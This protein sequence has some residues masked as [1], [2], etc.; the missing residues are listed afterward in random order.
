[1]T[2]AF[3]LIPMRK[4]REIW[5]ALPAIEARKQSV[6]PCAV[7]GNFCFRHVCDHDRSEHDNQARQ[8]S[9]A[10]C[11]HAQLYVY[12]SIALCLC[13]GTADIYFRIYTCN[14][15]GGVRRLLFMPRP[16]TRS[17]RL[18]RRFLLTNSKIRNHRSRLCGNV[19]GRRAAVAHHQSRQASKGNLMCWRK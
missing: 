5:C 3:L 11:V 16:L 10:T 12:A 13:H 18:S 14:C 1:M 8:R 6:F 15:M 7:G 2:F 19:G 4:L 17:L 9:I